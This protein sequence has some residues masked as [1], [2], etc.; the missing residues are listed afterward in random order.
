LERRLA[1][2]LAADVVG[3]SRLMGEDEAGTLERLKCLRRELVQPRITERKGRVVKLMGDGLLAEFP[4]VVEAVQCAVDIQRGMNER[5]SEITGERRI[6]LRIGINLGDIIVE[7][8]DIYGDGVNVAARLEALSNPGCICVSGTVFDSVKGKVGLDFE[9]LGEQQLKN[10]N[11]PVRVYRVVLVSGT[12]DGE[13]A[14]TSAGSTAVLE[15]P[16][17]PSVAILPFSNMSGDPEQEYFADGITEDIITELSRFQSIFVIARN[18]AFTYK[19]RAVRVQDVG[20]NLGVRYVVEGSVRKAGE[21]VRVTV[22]LIDAQSGNHIWAERYDR[23]LVDI[24]ELQDELTQ[25]IVATLPGR[26]ES[27]DIERFKR[28]PFHDISAYDCVLRAKLSHHRGTP[29]DNAEG[30]RLLDQAI[31]TDPDCA[32]AYAWKGCTLAQSYTR[33]YIEYSDELEEEIYQ[34][35][36]KGLSLDEN[37]LECV[38]TLCEFRIEQNRL[39]DAF[40][41]NEKALRINPNDPRIVAQRG[42]IL[43]WLGQPE[44][45]VEWI[46]KA[47]RL[48]PYDAD[49]WAH[50]L[51]RALFGARQYRDA[52]S[53]FKRIP[54][55]RYS[56]HAFLAACLAY[57]GDH[58]RA[59]IECKEVLRLKLNFSAGDFCN[60]ALFYD[61]DADRQ[62]LGQGL[63]KAGLPE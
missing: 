19:D 60:K 9:D 15:L 8:S 58:D 51:G 50:L 28:T 43:T 59:E 10:I 26:V 52:V 46:R 41:L 6:R 18:S 14:N 35:V 42:E 16:Q 63:I 31:N 55:M 62:H 3:Y 45:G 27:A 54:L 61:D 36:L 57:L 12:N 23:N 44:D 2:I 4:S 7:G 39:D 5:E 30:I 47:M 56:H 1:A 34:Y 13:G 37:D 38:R 33:G 24:F 29:E 53:A 22:Q 32:S 11:D 49:A 48:D 17:K 25:S 40:L 21:R 20:Q